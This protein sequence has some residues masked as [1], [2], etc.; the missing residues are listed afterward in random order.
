MPAYIAACDIGIVIIGKYQIL[1]NNSANK[2]FDILSSGKPVLLNYSGWQKQIIDFW[3]A[4]I[5]CRLCNPEEFIDAVSLLSSDEQLRKLM[6]VNSRKLAK[7]EY[8]R[9]KI[10]LSILRVLDD[11]PQLG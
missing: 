3:K 6:G 8:D 1:Q 4:G 2:F 11:M 10:A 9:D 5:G 7:K